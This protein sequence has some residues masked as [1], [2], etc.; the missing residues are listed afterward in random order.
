[1]EI[2][3]FFTQIILCTLQVSLQY[4][5]LFSVF[6]VEIMNWSNGGYIF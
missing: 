6:I 5:Y 3:L 4:S 1:M 2:S